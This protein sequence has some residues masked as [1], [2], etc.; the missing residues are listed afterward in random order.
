M[1]HEFGMILETPFKTMYAVCVLHGNWK[2]FYGLTCTDRRSFEVYLSNYNIEYGM[3]FVYPLVRC[4]DNAR[5]LGLF[6][7][8]IRTIVK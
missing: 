3:K 7:D 6:L 1:F 8:N 2:T 5:H 4:V